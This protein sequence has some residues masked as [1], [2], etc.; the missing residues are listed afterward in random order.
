M[1]ILKELR[2]D[3]PS[4]GLVFTSMG[5]GSVLTAFFVI[6]WLRSWFSSKTLILI[7][8]VSLAGIYLLMAI[9]HHCIYCIIVMA[10]AGASWTLAASELWVSI[11]RVLPDTIRGRGNALVMILSQ[12]AMTIGGLAWGMSATLAGTRPSL[13][14]AASAFLA[15]IGA[16]LLSRKPAFGI[17]PNAVTVTFTQI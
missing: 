9:V 4:L 8:Q 16:T 5:V 6:P 3:A 2:L 14:A 1:L 15:V 17:V 10:L 13:L 11:Q 12:G 7:S